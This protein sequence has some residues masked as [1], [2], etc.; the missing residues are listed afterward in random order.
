MLLW[1]EKYDYMKSI[2]HRNKKIE[3]SK[4]LWK[5][6]NCKKNKDPGFEWF[7]KIGPDIIFRSLSSYKPRP[8]SQMHQS[9]EFHTG[10][11]RKL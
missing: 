5:K 9:I 8:I 11:C 1:I 3:F 7:W 4:I 10:V 6:A 2:D